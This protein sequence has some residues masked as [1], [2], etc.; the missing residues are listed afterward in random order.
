M[1]GETALTTDSS[2]VIG[3]EIVLIKSIVQIL[4]FAVLTGISAGLKLEIGAV[5]VTAQTLIVLLSGALLGSKKGA[6][7]QFTYLAGG[8]LGL[9]WFSRGGGIMY[10]MSP[11]FGYILGFTLAAYLVGL[12][13]ERGWDQNIRKS[14]LAILIANFA[15]YIPGLLWLSRFVGFSKVLTVGL[16]P[17]VVGDILKIS[18]VTM[19]LSFTLKHKKMKS[20]NN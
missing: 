12:L 2:Q 17:F 7:S 20:L 16:Y 15:I 6:L 1:K 5:P 9:P 14:A 11:T 3:K 8:L 4:G 19:I 13:F 10:I 18:L